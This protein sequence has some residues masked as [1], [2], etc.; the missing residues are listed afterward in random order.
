MK[1]LAWLQIVLGGFSV[2]A[3]FIRAD[4]TQIFVGCFLGIMG[5]VN[6]RTSGK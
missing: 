6:L 4:E 1:G 3:G 2:A 5:L